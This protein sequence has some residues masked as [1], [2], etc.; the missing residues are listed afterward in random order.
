MKRYQQTPALEEDFSNVPLKFQGLF[1]LQYKE[2]FL[3]TRMFIFYK[4][5]RLTLRNVSFVTRELD[6]CRTQLHR[7]EWGKRVEKRTCFFFLVIPFTL[8]HVIQ[9]YISYDLVKQSFTILAV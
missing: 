7:R 2:Y 1:L 6:L 4:R 5:I 9:I 3:Y 8:V